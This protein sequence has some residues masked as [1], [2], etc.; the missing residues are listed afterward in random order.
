MLG[1]NP[2]PVRL[3]ENGAQELIRSAVAEEDEM[4]TVVETTDTT[5]MPV[6]MPSRPLSPIVPDSSDDSVTA[7][8]GSSREESITPS[9]VVVIEPPSGD[10]HLVPTDAELLAD[11]SLPTAEGLLVDLL[12]APVAPRPSGISERG[13]PCSSDKVPNVAAGSGRP[14]SS[15]A[16]NCCT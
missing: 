8:M 15:Q 12:W 4:D 10:V 6:D 3:L 5:D 11:S 13:D 16:V 9:E 2:P 1:D 7:I 14:V